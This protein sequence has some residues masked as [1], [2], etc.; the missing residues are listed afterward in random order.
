MLWQ[1]SQVDSITQII[2][3]MLFQVNIAFSE[4]VRL[5]FWLWLLHPPL[6]IEI[7]Q[8]SLNNDVCLHFYWRVLLHTQP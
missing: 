1:V 5:V 2:L 3:K 4:I 6:V 8:C 7:Y